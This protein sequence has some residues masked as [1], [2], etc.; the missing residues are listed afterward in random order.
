M[1][2]RHSDVGVE[3]WR[4]LAARVIEAARALGDVLVVIDEAH[5]VA[6]QRGKV[7]AAVKGLATTGRGEGASSIW[8]T[9]RLSEAEETVI[10]QCQARLLGGF[11]SSADLGKVDAITEYPTDVHNPQVTY[12]PNLPVRLEPRGR[13]EPHSLQKHIEDGDTVGSEW[14]YSDNTGKRERRNTR[15][16]AASMQSTHYGKQGKGL[17]V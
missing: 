2:A 8:V 3:A 1:V 9:Q 16:L 11:E 12:V 6:P 10:S 7:P 15:G 14:I 13:K 5:F 4:K 17:K